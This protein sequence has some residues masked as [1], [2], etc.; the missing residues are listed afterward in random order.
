MNQG[1]LTKYPTRRRR[2]V[3]IKKIWS[4]VSRAH[5]LRTVICTI[6]NVSRPWNFSLIL[7][8]ISFLSQRSPFSST[9]CS[10]FSINWPRVIGSSFSLMRMVGRNTPNTPLGFRTLWVSRNALSPA[11]LGGGTSRGQD[12]VELIVLKVNFQVISLNFDNSI[13]SKLTVADFSCT[14][15]KCS[16]AIFSSI[17]CT[18]N[19]W[20]GELLEAT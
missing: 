12:G 3:S 1:H 20:M 10:Y 7:D 2:I 14:R 4:H 15:K 18:T 19:L 9:R 6:S 16:G 5:A 11:L 8:T 13:T 17:W